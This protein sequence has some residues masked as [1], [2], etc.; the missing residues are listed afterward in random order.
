MKNRYRIVNRL[1]QILC[2]QDTAQKCAD[3][4]YN[5]GKFHDGF[6]S[7]DTKPGTAYPFT[8]Y[9][10]EFVGLVGTPYKTMQE[11]AQ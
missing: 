3:V 5:I 1:G 6:I 8:R 7:I 9:R 11:A 10:W 4:I 2:H